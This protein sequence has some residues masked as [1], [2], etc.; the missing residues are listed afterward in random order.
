MAEGEDAVA[1]QATEEV[2]LLSVS[3]RFLQKRKEWIEKRKA[4]EEEETKDLG[5]V[6]EEVIHLMQGEGL[7]SQV[8][9]PE[10]EGQATVTITLGTHGRRYG[11]PK[12]EDLRHYLGD[13]AEAFIIQAVDPKFR[14]NVMKALKAGKTEIPREVLD[15][16]CPVTTPGKLGLKVTDASKEKKKDGGDADDE[17]E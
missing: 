2:D 13:G 14:A 9:P 16:L 1:S 15:I 7:K 3:R 4:F 17:D 6:R 10:K 5:P 8:V 11:Q 12:P